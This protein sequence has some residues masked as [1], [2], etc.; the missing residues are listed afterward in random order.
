MKWELAREQTHKLSRKAVMK[1]RSG[2]LELAETRGHELG[3][4][5]QLLKQSK[6]VLRAGALHDVRESLVPNNMGSRS[7]AHDH[8][9]VNFSKPKLNLLP[10]FRTEELAC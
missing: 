3:A 9:E 1:S 8:S 10:Q 2:G 6:S 5:A 4:V 7:K